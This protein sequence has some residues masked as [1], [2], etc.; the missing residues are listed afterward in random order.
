MKAAQKK[1]KAVKS[2]VEKENKGKSVKS[3]KEKVAANLAS[4][5]TK[6]TISIVR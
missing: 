6:R 3:D 2:H 5:K 1:A 4:D